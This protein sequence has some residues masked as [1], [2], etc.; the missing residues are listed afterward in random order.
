MYMYKRRLNIDLFAKK[1]K[2]EIAKPISTV[3]IFV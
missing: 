3:F 2:K 1:K